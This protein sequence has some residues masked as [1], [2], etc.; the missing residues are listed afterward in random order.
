MEEHATQPDRLARWVDLPLLWIGSIGLLIM[1]AATVLSAFGAAVFSRP[2]P[3]IV[4]LDEVLMAFVVFLPLALVQLHRDHIEVG[5]ATDWLPPRKLM[6]VQVFGMV[7]SLLV[8][9][10][11]FYALAI[12][13]HEAYLDNDLYTG[14]YSIPSWP[15][16]TIAALGVLGFL[17]RLVADIVQ[18]TRRIRAH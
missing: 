6:M 17:V 5:I 3:D 2:V 18:T 12:G 11:L 15:M 13:A 8:F 14:E 9:G 4:T 16:R 7:V 1:M 10:L